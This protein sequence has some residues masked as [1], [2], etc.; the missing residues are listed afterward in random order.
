MPDDFENYVSNASYELPAA[1]AAN[2]SNSSYDNDY[3]GY[4]NGG[5]YDYGT[6]ERPVGRLASFLRLKPNAEQLRWA[7]EKSSFAELARQE[8]AHGFVERTIEAQR[9]FE[10]APHRKGER[11]CLN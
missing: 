4:D 11:S 5:S 10:A 2:T 3:A 9:F 7:I 6:P 1:G 8:A